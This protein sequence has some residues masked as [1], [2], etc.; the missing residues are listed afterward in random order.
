M[1][2]DYLLLKWCCAACFSYKKCA[3]MRKG[4]RTRTQR[5]A[6]IVH[7]MSNIIGELQEVLAWPSGTASQGS[8]S[9][10]V[11]EVRAHAAAGQVTQR[12]ASAAASDFLLQ[13]GVQ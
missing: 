5:I 3:G 11:A 10:F 1:P 6:T 4:R 9:K 2:H 12:E 7:H 13:Y 8:A